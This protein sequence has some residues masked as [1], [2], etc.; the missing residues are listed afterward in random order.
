MSTKSRWNNDVRSGGVLPDPPPNTTE[1]PNPPAQR[2]PPAATPEPP[3]AGNG[4]EVLP[5][6]LA[7]LQ[8]R[9]E[10]GYEKYGTKLRCRNGRNAL[11]D[12]YQEALDLAMYLRQALEEQTLTEQERGITSE[13]A[14][15]T[16]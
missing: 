6:V 4:R 15:R 10:M 14:E 13:R 11:L 5:L 16:G 8:A 1:P 9:A 2:R 12:A 7:D 3:P